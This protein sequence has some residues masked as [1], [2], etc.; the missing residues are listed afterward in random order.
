M[1]TYTCRAVCVPEEEGGYSAFVRNLPGVHSQ[2]ESL[3]EA[4]NNIREAF[5]GTVAAYL[6]AGEE[7]PWDNDA[8]L[9]E[10]AIERQMA[11]QSLNFLA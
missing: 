7:I 4:L 3:D 6:A 8:A 1:S 5:A 9:P 11:L 2:G 10:G